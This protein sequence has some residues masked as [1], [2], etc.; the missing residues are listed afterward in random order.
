MNQIISQVEEIIQTLK[1][2]GWDSLI[3]TEVLMGLK[4]IEEMLDK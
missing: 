2:E 4:K 3:F 1:S